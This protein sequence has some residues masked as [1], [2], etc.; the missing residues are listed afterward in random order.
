MVNLESIHEDFARNTSDNVNQWGNQ[1]TVNLGRIHKD[2]A[3]IT[4]DNVDPGGGDQWSSW[5]AST[6][7]LQGLPQ[8]KLILGG[9]IDRQRG[10]DPQKLSKDYL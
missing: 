3:R 7:T 5:K 4:S 9:S 6:K 10:K 2:F 1:S 8:I